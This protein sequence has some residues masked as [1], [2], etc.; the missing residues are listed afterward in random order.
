MRVAL[1]A[2]SSTIHVHVRALDV[3]IKGATAVLTEL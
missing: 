2:S 3:K 1:N